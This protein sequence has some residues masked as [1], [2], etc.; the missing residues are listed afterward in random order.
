MA[1]ALLRLVWR[2][3]LDNDPLIG[4]IRDA[5]AQRRKD[6]SVAGRNARRRE[7]AQGDEPVRSSSVSGSAEKKA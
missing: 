1:I 2:D 6:A 7:A 5:I 3:G 4:D